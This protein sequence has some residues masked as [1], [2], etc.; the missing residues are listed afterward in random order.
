M[1]IFLFLVF[2]FVLDLIKSVLVCVPKQEEQRR[3]MFIPFSF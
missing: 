3:V 1:A 2:F